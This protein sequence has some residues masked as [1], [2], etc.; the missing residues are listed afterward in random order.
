MTEFNIG[1]LASLSIIALA[2]MCFLYMWGGRSGKWKRRFIAAFIG[3]LTVNLLSLAMELWSPWLLTVFPALSIGF[4]L[5]Y[6]SDVFLTKVF[7]RSICALAICSAG[8]V[9]CFIFGGHA[10][11]ILPLHIGVGIWSV[12]LGVKNPVHAAAEETFVCLLLNA[13]LMMYPFV[14]V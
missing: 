2:I 10:W 8:L 1:L 13:G 14:T 9:C 6:G 5:G 11:M 12:W 4:H 3:A 7:K